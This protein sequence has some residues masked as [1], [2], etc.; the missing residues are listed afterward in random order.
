MSS[1]QYSF[2]KEG[3]SAIR[4]FDSRAWRCAW[5]TPSTQCPIPGNAPA[6]LRK[7]NCFF[8][9]RRIIFVLVPERRREMDDTAKISVGKHANMMR[10]V[11]V[12]VSTSDMGCAVM[13]VLLLSFG[14]VGSK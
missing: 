5:R 12:I 6:G 2:M 1:S 10:V 11:S 4:M 8:F 14:V 9:D 7:V 3:S 13:L